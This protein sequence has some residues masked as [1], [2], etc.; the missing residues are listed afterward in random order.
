MIKLITQHRRGTSDEW[1][2]MSHIIIA[3]GELVIEECPNGERKLKVGDGKRTF[4]QL[5]YVTTGLETLV[6][7][8]SGRMSLL[9]R[10]EQDPETDWQTEVEGIRYPIEGDAYECA[11]DAVRANEQ[12]I[13]DVSGRLDELQF[14][15]EAFIGADAV[16][17]LL[18]DENTGELIIKD[19]EIKVKIQEQEESMK[20]NRNFLEDI[21]L[22]F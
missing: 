1:L 6:N 15:L 19:N 18:Y 7:S 20:Q 10:S 14:D 3:D 4:A 22:N 16:N 2:L 5:P 9:E 11:G 12:A 8:L 17:G 21:M 13:K